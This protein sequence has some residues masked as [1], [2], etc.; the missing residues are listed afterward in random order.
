MHKKYQSKTIFLTQLFRLKRMPSSGK[1]QYKIMGGDF[2]LISKK[3]V[4]L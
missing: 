3:G 4:I 1:L 2:F